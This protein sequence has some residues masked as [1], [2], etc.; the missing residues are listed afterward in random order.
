MADAPDLEALR[1]ELEAA[2]QCGAA[3]FDLP[4]L[5]F[6]ERL[7]DAAEVSHNGARVRLAERA[8]ITLTKLVEDMDLARA[9]TKEKIVSAPSDRREALLNMV[10]RGEI[11]AVHFALRSTRPKREVRRP[12]ERT[13]QMKQE[14]EGRATLPP[15]PIEMKPLDV[16]TRLYASRRAESL[17]K[18][19][20]RVA[21]QDV[22]E[23][24]GPY[25]APTVAARTLNLLAEHPSLLRSWVAR[26]SSLPFDPEPEE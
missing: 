26:L 10:E 15:S 9:E 25:H 11:N 24:P 17:A 4:R 18:R 13:A 14:L 3:H 22:P 12:E 16:A 23:E 8:E 20:L 2:R 21:A 6:V 7:L 5:R 19:A 1:G